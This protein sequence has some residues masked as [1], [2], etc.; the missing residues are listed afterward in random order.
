MQLQ[1]RNI[2]RR[3]P[4]LIVID[5][6]GLAGRAVD[7]Y[8]AEPDEPTE[9]RVN[10][11]VHDWAGRAIAQWDPRLFL[12]ASA[13]ANLQTIHALSGAL[14]STNSV[15]A[16]WRVVLL[17]E[18]GQPLQH[19]DGRGS[20][21]WMRYDTQLRPE[22]VFEQ[23]M[24]GEA[25]CAERLSYGASDQAAAGHNRCGQ[26]IRHDDPAG[27]QRFSE[28]G[29]HGAV[30]GQTRHFLSALSLPDWPESVVDRELLLDPGEGATTRSHFN[31]LA[32]AIEQTDAKGHRQLFN[33][34]LDGQLREVRL[35]LNG[36]STPK[37]LVSAIRY[38]AH[39][40]TE[41][42]VAGNGVV[43]MLEY[44]AQNGRLTRLR[45][46]RGNAPL[47]DLRYEY[48]PVG[49]VLSIGDAALPIRY[50]ANQ[51]VEAVNRY[52]Y[53]SL[54]QLIDAMGWEAGGSNKGP[55]FSTFD[56]PA[57][58]ANFRQQY[59]Y[60][61][62]GN[63][64]ELIHEGPQN[65]GH[66]LVAAA[67]SNRCLPVI[68][69][70]EPGEDDFRRGF[71]GNGNL[72][73]LQLG[74]T[75]SWDLRNQLHEVRPVQRERGEDDC[76]RYVYGA[77]G[78]RLRKVREAHTNARTLIAETRYLPNLELRNYSGTGEVMQVIN[79]QAG[80]SSV[81]VLHWE[82]EP[83]KDS[84]NDQYRYHLNDHL[85]SCALELDGEGE[86]ISQERYHPFGTTTWFAGRGEVEASYKTVRYSGKERDVTGLYYYGFR[87]Y[88]AGWQRWL[89]PDPG[90]VADG[91][92]TFAFV[93]GSP[94]SFK[95]VQGLNRIDISNV[96]PRQAEIVGLAGPQINPARAM[97]N[98]NLPWW[99]RRGPPPRA[100]IQKVDE[101]VME[102]L[103]LADSANRFS[104]A[105]LPYGSMN[106][107]LD[108]FRSRGESI[109]KLD[110]ART[111]EKN[112]I[113]WSL[114]AGAGNCGEFANLNFKLLA[115]ASS[116]PDPIQRVTA[117]GADHG[118]VVI[119]DYRAPG[120]VYADAWPTFPLAHVGGHG[121]FSVGSVNYSLG[122]GP[123]SPDY[124]VDDYFLEKSSQI[125]F[126]LKSGS[127]DV[128]KRALKQIKGIE[129]RGEMYQQWFSRSDSSIIVQYQSPSRMMT[130]ALSK[131]YV[132]ERLGHYMAF[133]KARGK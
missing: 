100:L 28:F 43:T 91:L 95:D 83:P 37:V 75:L 112:P 33:Q 115:S 94:V 52:A 3:T 111:D 80:R 129:E 73:T 105:L 62:G 69:G 61:P 7:Y 117:L 35:Q 87:Y 60:D 124:Y 16:G 127:K 108:A 123:V 126:P 88:M 14:L 56:D 78:M 25:V 46:Q 109:N 72:L 82:S 107:M 13:P 98:L 32:E 133:K 40:Q 1:P 128:D 29:L 26:L 77:D 86:V 97:Q 76:E 120:A 49:N 103:N 113:A 39:G 22:L 57:P 41:R 45:A 53:D 6:R 15:D 8:R 67:H 119:G 34:T 84:A 104:K 99:D 65:H 18:A 48:D 9:I 93:H 55:P 50:F 58:C 30:L 68:E 81:R 59:R 11:T 71:D 63:L 12:D 21:R 4:K 116:R 132:D 114:H 5:P 79:V 20:Q 51:R 101:R 89:N 2:H 90:G 47:Q 64:L 118:F 102:R 19:W 27:T 125:V 106:Q 23:V 96:T 130:P 121:R 131:R 42:E 122:V 38:N 110:I 31:A 24:H 74:Q 66:R 92:N 70:K 10:R 44:D 54:S 17:G 36:A 85:G